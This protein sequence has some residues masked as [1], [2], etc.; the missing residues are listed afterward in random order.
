MLSIGEVAARTGLSV[1]VLRKYEREGLLLSPVRRDGAG[2]RLYDPVDV[3]WLRNCVRLRE[4]DMPLA[5]I[6]RYVELVKAGNGTERERIAI[7]QRHR[8]RLQ[9]RRNAIDGALSLINHKIELY[10]DHVES[11]ATDAPWAEPVR[12]A[13]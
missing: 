8:T 9:D 4:S 10:E 13:D 5:D 12:A 6:R 1:H 11:G 3:D 2:R 7:L